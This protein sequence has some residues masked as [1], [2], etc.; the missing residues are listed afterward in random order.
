MQFFFKLLVFYLFM[1]CYM[2]SY[3][4]PMIVGSKSTN[5]VSVLQRTELPIHFYRFLLQIP[6]ISNCYL[7]NKNVNCNLVRNTL[8]YSNIDFTVNQIPPLQYPESYDTIFKVYRRFNNVLPQ[9]WQ[10]ILKEYPNNEYM[11]ENKPNLENP[12]ANRKTQRNMFDTLQANG[13]YKN[14]TVSENMDIH[15]SLT[16]S[17]AFIKAHE[18]FDRKF[19][20]VSVFTTFLFTFLFFLLYFFSFL[21]EFIINL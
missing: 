17:R 9:K 3:E 18:N 15:R 19:Y 8:D 13:D 7:Q 4:L 14:V 21:Y 5:H 2:F 6:D 1:N 16:I 12:V 11:Q 10:K 20:N